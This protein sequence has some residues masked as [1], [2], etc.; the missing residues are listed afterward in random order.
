MHDLCN[1]NI[2]E[3]RCQVLLQHLWSGSSVYVEMFSDQT[4][5][6]LADSTFQRLTF[7][8]VNSHFAN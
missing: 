4:A 8:K 6:N 5:A 3:I 1:H 2:Y 7:I